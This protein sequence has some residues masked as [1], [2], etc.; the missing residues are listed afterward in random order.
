MAA[1]LH[2]GRTAY[3]IH[4]LQLE[5]LTV[6]RREVGADPKHLGIWTN[7]SDRTDGG[8]VLVENESTSS[9]WNEAFWMALGAGIILSYFLLYGT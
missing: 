9:G 4:T 8:V 5:G 6:E 7:G 3:V 2:D 1:N